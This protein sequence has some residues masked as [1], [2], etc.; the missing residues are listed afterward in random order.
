MFFQRE[1][2]GHRRVYLVLGS[3]SIIGLSICL[4]ECAVPSSEGPTEAG[5]TAASQYSGDA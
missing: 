2:S 5:V 3:E 4:L 1:V